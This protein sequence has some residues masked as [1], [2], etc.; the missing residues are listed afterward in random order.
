MVLHEGAVAEMRTGEGKTL[1]ATLAAYLNALPGGGV[2]VVTVN[3]YLATR[4]AKWCVWLACCF[5]AC[6]A[7][8]GALAASE[9]DCL[10]HARGMAITWLAAADDS[11]EHLCQRR[12]HWP[13]GTSHIALPPSTSMS[14]R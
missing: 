6:D 9:A 11:K 4:D 12:L 3:D 1:T 5:A 13:C 8:A 7:A 2:H 14:A 10:G